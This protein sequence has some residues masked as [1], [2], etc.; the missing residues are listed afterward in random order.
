M[1]LSANFNRKEFECR[2]GCKMPPD[3][4]V[5]TFRLAEN[6]QAIRDYFNAPITINSAYRCK[7]HNASVGGKKSSFHI[8]GLASDLDVHGY[9]PEE[10]K[11]GIEILIK[12][13]KILQGGVGLY[14]T[15][16]HYDIRRTKA[17]WDFRE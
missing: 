17:R 8:K 14:N 16:V 6:V 1:K 13:G 12:Q 2:C 5:N 15:F 4:L 3:V 9:S 10:V 7:K 11:E